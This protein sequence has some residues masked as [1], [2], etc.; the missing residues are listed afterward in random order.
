LDSKKATVLIKA[1]F[2]IYSITDA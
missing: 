1:V 2:I